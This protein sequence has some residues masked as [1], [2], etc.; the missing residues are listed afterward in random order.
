MWLLRIYRALPGIYQMVLGVYQEVVGIYQKVIGVYQK[1]FEVYQMHT[2]SGMCAPHGARMV[3]SRRGGAAAVVK[4]KDG[5]YVL[6]STYQPS[7][8][9]AEAHTNRPFI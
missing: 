1:G 6:S 8:S 5:W 7:F 2:F 4:E 9:L 3:G